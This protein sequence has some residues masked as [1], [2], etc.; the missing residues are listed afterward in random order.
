MKISIKP[1]NAY[2][3]FWVHSQQQHL[4]W[5]LKYFFNNLRR[6]ILKKITCR[7]QYRACH[8]FSRQQQIN[9]YNVHILQ[10]KLMVHHIMKFDQLYICLYMEEK[11]KKIGVILVIFLRIFIPCRL[12]IQIRN[13]KMVFNIYGTWHRVTFEKLMMKI[14][15]FFYSAKSFSHPI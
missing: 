1:S 13:M 12:G 3:V 14:Y 2:M 15:D 8:N 9:Q 11:K 5:P 10:K 6:N 7:V 4:I